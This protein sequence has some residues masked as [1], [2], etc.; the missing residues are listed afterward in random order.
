MYSAACTS[1]NNM[2]VN[3]F[4]QCTCLRSQSGI[5]QKEV[6]QRGSIGQTANWWA[7][8]PGTQ[9]S[10]RQSQAGFASSCGRTW[11]IRWGSRRAPRLRSSCTCRVRN[12][13]IYRC[14]RRCWC[15]GIRS[16]RDNR[17]PSGIDPRGSFAGRMACGCAG[18]VGVGGVGDDH[19]GSVG[20]SCGSGL[21]ESLRQTACEARE[22]SFEATSLSLVVSAN[23]LL[24]NTWLRAP[25][26]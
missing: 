22:S 19:V 6:G 20:G 8:R 9:V 18:G 13:C 11:C 12:W 4:S 24:R 15:R 16:R 10:R 14:W 7:R 5:G 21:S 2:A 3:T 25:L 17:S 23:C 26:Q 1:H